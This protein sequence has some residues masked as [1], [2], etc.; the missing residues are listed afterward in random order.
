M[1]EVVF[2]VEEGQVIVIEKESQAVQVPEPLYCWKMLMQIQSQIGQ[3]LESWQHPH[4][5]EGDE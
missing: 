1:Q 2:Q 3:S 5:G 4:L